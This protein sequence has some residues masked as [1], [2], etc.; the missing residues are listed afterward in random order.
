MWPPEH[1][2]YNNVSS[3][4]RHTACL[5]QFIGPSS[6]DKQ[7]HGQCALHGHQT[8]TTHTHTQVL[9]HAKLRESRRAQCK[10]CVLQPLLE[11]RYTRAWTSASRLAS[12]R[13]RVPVVLTAV[14]TGFCEVAKSSARAAWMTATAPS[15]VRFTCGCA[16]TQCCAANTMPHI[17]LASL[18]TVLFAWHGKVAWAC[19][20]LADCGGCGVASKFMQVLVFVPCLTPTRQAC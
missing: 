7:Q 19:V 6:R 8:N 1:H 13:V 5:P 20:P 17:S 14:S 15:T 10:N 16:Y 12:I 2:G 4:Q 9:L 11:E 18:Q 3:Q